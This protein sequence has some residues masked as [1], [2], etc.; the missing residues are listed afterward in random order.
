MLDTG[1]RRLLVFAPAYNESGAIVRVILAVRA[2]APG[3]QV[4]VVDDG[5]ADDTSACARSAGARV[6]R[7]PYN[8]G[9]G[10]AVQTGLR[11]ACAEGYDLVIRVDGDGQHNHEDIPALYGAFCAQ[12]ADAA[13]GSR[14]LP[15]G[16]W[17][18]HR[19]GGMPI[20][21]ARRAG[22]I[23]FACLV[24]ALTG[25]RATDPTSGF[26]CYSRRA[27]SVLAAVLPQDYPEVEGRIILH[28]AGLRVVETPTQMHARRDGES[29]I[30]MARSIYYA[31]KVSVA[32]AL[33]A[34]RVE[35]RDTVPEGQVADGARRA[36]DSTAKR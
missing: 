13:F 20:P 24:T 25:Q 29:S 8:L 31:F 26:A 36:G 4:L 1:S 32:A 15:D 17:R 28:R 35:K 30:T 21:L 6:V 14:F 11:Y 2:T 18:V 22:I 27:A 23:C 34:V 9:I 19:D 3:A 10:A 16:P 5:S 7:H 12:G 33:A